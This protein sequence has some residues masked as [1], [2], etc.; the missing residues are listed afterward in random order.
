MADPFA[1]AETD[2]AERLHRE[3]LER[4]R[5]ERDRRRDNQPMPVGSLFDDVTRQQ[6]SLF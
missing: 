1:Q 6:G 5:R 2:N 3:A 4:V